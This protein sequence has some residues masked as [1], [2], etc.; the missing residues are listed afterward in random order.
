MRCV[1]LRPAP[2]GGNVRAEPF[3][4]AAFGMG[5]CER[6]H[7][8]GRRDEERRIVLSDRLAAERDRQIRLAHPRRADQEKR[9]AIMGDPAAGGEFADLVRIHPPLVLARHLALAEEGDGLAQR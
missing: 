2:V 6:R 5:V 9:V 1:H 7:E 3:L 4:E 8:G